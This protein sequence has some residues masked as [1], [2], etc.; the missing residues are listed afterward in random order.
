[1]LSDCFFAAPGDIGGGLP[2]LRLRDEPSA[3]GSPCLSLGKMSGVCKED[4]DP[5]LVGL[6]FEMSG[7]L[8]LP[9]IPS[10]R[11]AAFSFSK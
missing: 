5:V 9:A 3:R 4:L 8:N 10:P 2:A 7:E 1:V 11:V 6:E